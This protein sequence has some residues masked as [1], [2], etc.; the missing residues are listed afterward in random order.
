MVIALSIVALA[1]VLISVGALYQYAG[2]RRD[3][4]LY[5]SEGR[6]VSIG[7]GAKLYLFELGAGEPTVVMESGIGATHLN[8]R[9]IQ[10]AVAQFAGTVSYDRGGLGWSSPCQGTR[11]PTK[12]AGE[13]VEMLENAGFKPPYILVGHSFGGLVMR[14]FALLYPEKV[15]SILLIDPMRC[16]E[17][18]PLDPGKH[19]E[20]EMGKKMIRYATPITRCGLARLAV[21]LL[22]RHAGKLPRQLAETAVPN[23]KYAIDRITTE[24]RKMP[25]AVWPIVAAHWSRPGFYRGLRCHLESIPETVREMH[26]AE[27]ICTIPITLLTPGNATPLNE[28][29]L[30][31]IGDNV[32]QVIAPQSQHWIHLDEPDLVIDCIRAMVD[33]PAAEEVSVRKW[34]TQRNSAILEPSFPVEE[35]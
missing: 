25:R 7:R 14:R 13:L 1:V 28:N 33:S 5:S 23:G 32:Q 35:F 30:E 16:E 27:P 6:F 12:I 3:R 26:M 19:S 15:A 11:T 24:V 18:P 4:A 2:S 29:Q 8:W 31:H 34:H 9:Y 17:W 22:F 10:E 20:L 21:R